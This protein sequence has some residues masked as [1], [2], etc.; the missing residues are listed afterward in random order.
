METLMHVA[1]AI[2]AFVFII[3]LVALPWSGLGFVMATG[4]SLVCGLVGMILA[5]TV[6][7]SP[8]EELAITMVLITAILYGIVYVPIVWV[9]KSSRRNPAV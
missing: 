6:N 8:S 7:G 4:F 5:F 9:V 1:A 3:G 2:V